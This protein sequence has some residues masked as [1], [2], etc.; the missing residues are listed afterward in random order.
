MKSFKEFIVE[1]NQRP[2]WIIYHL[3]PNDSISRTVLDRLLNEAKKSVDLGQGRMI[4]HHKAHIPGGQDHLH[5]HAREGQL[6]ALNKDGS[7]HDQSHGRTMHNWAINGMKQHYSGFT[8]PSKGIIENLYAD[9]EATVLTESFGSPSPVL[10]LPSTMY[11]AEQM[12][13]SPGSPS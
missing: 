3:H 10:V 4:Y 1:E 8:V 6:Y 9:T 5:F 13:G 7:A 11:D 12:L 2:A